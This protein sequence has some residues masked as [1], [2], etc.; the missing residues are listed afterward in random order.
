DARVASRT[1]QEVSSKIHG[2]MDTIAVFNAYAYRALEDARATPARTRDLAVSVS[3]SFTSSLDAFSSQ[4]NHI[5]ADATRASDNLDTLEAKLSVIHAL[6]LNE[7]FIA[8]V[9]HDK[10]LWDISAIFHGTYQ[11]KRRDLQ[12]RTAV[13]E[14]VDRY[15]SLAASYVSVTMQ[16]LMTIDTDLS[17]LRDRV[18]QPARGAHD[19]PM[20]VQLAS[21]E[22]T[23]SRL[24]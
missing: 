8:G 19:I 12:Y 4:I 10:L 1:L 24:K 18:F 5:V 21:I 13:L 14:D 3:R 7:T 16:V 2:F 6:C 17:E 20:E 9:A 22:R 15:R 23:L 11:E